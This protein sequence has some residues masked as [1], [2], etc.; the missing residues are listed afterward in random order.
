MARTTTEIQAE[1]DSIT[2]ALNNIRVAGQSWE[3]T[4]GTGAGTKRVVTMAEYDKLVA[5][6]DE[7]YAELREAQGRSVRVTRPGW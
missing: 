6:R 2:T 1:I 4:S 5:H 7:L 3:I